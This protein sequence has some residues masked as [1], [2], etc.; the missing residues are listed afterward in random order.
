MQYDILHRLVYFMQ[1]TYLSCRGKV[2]EEY[3]DSVKFLYETCLFFVVCTYGVFLSVIRRLYF[4]HL[5]NN[6]H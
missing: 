3:S 5:S 2:K 4:H 6:I 1:S